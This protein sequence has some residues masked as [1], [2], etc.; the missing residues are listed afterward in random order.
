MA[1]RKRATT[2]KVIARRIKEKRGVG[3]GSNYKPWLNIHDVPS[4]GMVTRTMSE[5]TGRIHHLMSENLEFAYHITLEWS[6]M[7]KDIREQ[8]PLLPIEESQSIAEETGI[9]YPVDPKT[10]EPIVLTTDFLI[11]IADDK[12]LREVART[13][14]HSNKLTKRQLEKFEIE[15]RF[16]QKRGI[17]WGVV[18]ENDINYD[19]VNN[20]KWI[21]RAKSLQD[22]DIDPEKIK[23]V[24]PYLFEALSRS[25]RPTSLV[26]EEVDLKFGLRPGGCL[27]I[28]RYMIANRKW[29]IE[30]TRK[31]DPSEQA[32][33]LYLPG[34]RDGE[35]N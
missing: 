35:W 6:K 22:I 10:R 16:Y 27:F 7:V 20:I 28:V 33:R 25:W 19:L 15:R 12:G 24:E 31:F 13:L 23:I 11:T 21:R 9:T 18:T 1:K 29:L 5:T 32:L 14:K 2:K 17:D 8:Y 34:R 26:C 3:T 30:M 4:I